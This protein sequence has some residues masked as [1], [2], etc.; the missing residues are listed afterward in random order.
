[1]DRV[2]LRIEDQ[3]GGVVRLTAH[4][5]VTQETNAELKAAFERVLAGKPRRVD[6]D[7][8]GVDYI[9]S[10][11]VGALVSL[12]RK[13]RESN[14]TLRILNLQPDIAQLFAVTHLDKI[15]TVERETAAETAR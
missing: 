7:C 8:A 14:A 6:F 2:S 10:A 11:G 3:G 4:G 5:A 15:F 1:M 13:L 12:L 9:A